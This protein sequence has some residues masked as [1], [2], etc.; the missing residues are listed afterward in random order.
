MAID[1]LIAAVQEAVVTEEDRRRLR[2]RLNEADR[3]FEEE[4]LAR[5]RNPQD[6]LNFQYTL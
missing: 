6:F 2:E 4:M 5:E 1:K 3:R